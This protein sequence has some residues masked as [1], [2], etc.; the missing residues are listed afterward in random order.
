MGSS[1]RQ[2]GTIEVQASLREPSNVRLACVLRHSVIPLRVVMLRVTSRGL[3]WTAAVLIVVIAIFLAIANVWP[4]DNPSPQLGSDPSL[5]QLML[6]DHITLGFVRFSLVLLAVF[7]VASVP[8]LVVGGRWLKG[9]GTSGLTADDAADA[10]KT[11]E[12]AKTKLDA[13][14]KELDAVTRERDEAIELLREV[15]S[16]GL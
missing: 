8:A 14:A 1:T 9:F 13:T 12:E 5:W 10:S 6:S 16:G 3:Q 15:A 7:V 11:L 4:F 2:T